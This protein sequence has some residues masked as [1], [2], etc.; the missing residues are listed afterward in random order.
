MHTRPVNGEADGLLAFLAH[1]REA[2]RIACFG[3][4]DEQARLT[5]I[6]SALSAGGLVKHLASANGAGR[7][8][9][10][11]GHWKTTPTRRRP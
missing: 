3:L 6:P 2:V 1:Q 8:A 10:R 4:T 7:D 11:K 5:P 9:W